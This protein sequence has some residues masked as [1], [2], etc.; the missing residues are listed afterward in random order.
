[1]QSIK[2]DHLIEQILCAQFKFKIQLRCSI[3]WPVLIFWALINKNQYY[4]KLTEK[5]VNCLAGKIQP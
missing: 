2:E 3:D 5:N 1:M 4:K